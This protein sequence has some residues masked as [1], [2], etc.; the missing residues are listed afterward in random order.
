MVGSEE[1]AGKC[2]YQA[3]FGWLPPWSIRFHFEQ[4]FQL[5]NVCQRYSCSATG[6]F[7]DIV[8]RRRLVDLTMVIDTLPDPRPSSEYS[9]SITPCLSDLNPQFDPLGKERIDEG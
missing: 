5:S 9:Q 1:S 6:S 3:S 7:I 8:S 2:D 4:I